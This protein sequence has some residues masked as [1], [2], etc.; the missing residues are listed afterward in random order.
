[1]QS[2]IKKVCLAISFLILSG[3]SCFADSPLR[4]TQ[5]FEAY[6]D[7]EIVKIAAE[8]DGVL[9]DKLIDFIL[10]KENPID[11]KLAAINR[12]VLLKENLYNSEILVN[13]AIENGLYQNKSELYRLSDADLKICLAYLQAFDEK[14]SLSVALSTAWSATYR[15]KTSFSIHIIYAIIEAQMINY[16]DVWCKIYQATDKVRQNTSLKM[17]MKPEAVKI[18]FEYMDLYQEYCEE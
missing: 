7:E 14:V 18:I 13:Y 3:H 5:F 1:M 12:L 10:N 2:W 8:A 17:D 15:N 6:K 9:N 4:S 16:H 11:L